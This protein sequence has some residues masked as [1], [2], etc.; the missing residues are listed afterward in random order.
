MEPL[1]KC[2]NPLRT[3]TIG[4]LFVGFQWAKELW[5]RDIDGDRITYYIKLDKAEREGFKIFTLIIFKAAFSFCWV[6]I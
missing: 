5:A 2:P 4:K 6:T 1:Y 3:F